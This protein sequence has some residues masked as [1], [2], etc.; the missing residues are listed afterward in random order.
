MMNT[1]T[2]RDRREEN[3]RTRGNTGNFV[4]KNTYMRPVSLSDVR[5]SVCACI[6]RVAERVYTWVQSER[7]NSG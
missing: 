5:K 3:E 4:V 7:A 1:E 2:D 6:Q